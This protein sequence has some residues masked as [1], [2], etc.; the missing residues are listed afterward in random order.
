MNTYK[1]QLLVAHPNITE[2]VFARSVIFVYQDDGNGTLGFILNKPTKWTVNKLLA[3]KGIPYEG[4]EYVYK[5][6]P[7]NES[8]VVMLHEDNWYSSNTIQVSKGLAITSDIHMMQKL[9]MDNKPVNWRMF[10][11]IAGWSPGQLALE[12]RSRNGWLTC[13]AD[14]SIVFAKDGERQWNSAVQS[15]ASQTID[16]YF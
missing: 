2:G 4:P 14:P 15:C 8:A 12:L 6:G 1:G 3:E 7:V 5:G 16:N 10:V 11:G 9:S 13:A